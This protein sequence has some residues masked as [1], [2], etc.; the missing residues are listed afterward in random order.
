MCCMCGLVMDLR[1]FLVC[2]HRNGVAM[3]QMYLA[4]ALSGSARKCSREA[5][6]V[7][8][9]RQ[10]Q[11]PRAQQQVFQTLPFDMA[12]RDSDVISIHTY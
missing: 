3:R 5:D 9:V 10:L 12:C 7:N 6:V 1:L 4:L 8:G 11:G 2:A